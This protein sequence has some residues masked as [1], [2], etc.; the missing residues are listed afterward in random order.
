MLQNIKLKLLVILSLTTL[1]IG[2]VYAASNVDI[3][4]QVT[5][6]APNIISVKICDGTCA[7]FKELSPATGFTIEIVAYDADDVNKAAT[8][9]E[10]YQTADSN[11]SGICDAWDHKY[12]AS[13]TTGDSQGCVEDANTDCYIV[14]SSAWSTKFLRGETDVWARV[15][16]AATTPLNDYE[17]LVYAASTTGIN[18]LATAGFSLD[19]NAGN[20]TGSEGSTNNP[21]VSVNT[22]GVGYIT[23]THLGNT[24]INLS[25]DAPV[26]TCA[27]GSCNGQTIASTNLKWA[28]S[29]GGTKTAFTGAD[30]LLKVWSRGSC[31][32]NATETIY[33]WLDVP[34]GQ[35]SG[36]YPGTYVI[37]TIV[38]E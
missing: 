2:G 5:N 24:D 12:L 10:F 28:L 17:E 37:S 8:L 6:G 32:T 18:T 9:I 33:T 13:L 25:M 4:A 15:S 30:D 26:L 7:V 29:S 31:G 22:G 21:F 38:S 19:E 35:M 27:T 14:P 1:F 20:Y 11:G 16:D 3:N 23:S 36:N 34:F